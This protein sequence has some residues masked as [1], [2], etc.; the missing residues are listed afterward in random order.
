[1]GIPERKSSRKRI[2]P[3]TPIDK[4]EKMGSHDIYRPEEH[5]EMIRRAEE[6]RGIGGE[7]TGDRIRETTRARQGPEVHRETRRRRIRGRGT[8]AGNTAEG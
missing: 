2:R 6:D 3:E 7:T 1:M 5:R 8:G 4:N